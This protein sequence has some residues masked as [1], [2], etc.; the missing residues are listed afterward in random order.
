MRELHE[1][2]KIVDI[3]ESKKG[4]AGYT[5]VG[6]RVSKKKSKLKQKHGH[7]VSLKSAKAS[8]VEGGVSAAEEGR[9]ADEVTE[10]QTTDFLGQALDKVQQTLFGSRP[11]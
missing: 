8:N 7:A 11:R 10:V 1:L 6:L 3:S 9:N 2:G 4:K 5:G